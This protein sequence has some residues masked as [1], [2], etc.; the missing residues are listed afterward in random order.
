[1]DLGT[2]SIDMDRQHGYGHATWTWKQNTD[3]DLQFGHDMQHGQVG[4]MLNVQVKVHA[5]PPC[6]C[7][8]SI[9]M[10]HAAYPWPC[11][12]LHVHG[13]A[14]C[15]VHA[16]YHSVWLSWR[17]FGEISLSCHFVSTTFRRNFREINL[18]FAICFW[19]N[20]S[21]RGEPRSVVRS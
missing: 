18:Y 16:A 13:H 4:Y 19:R 3:M 1:M 9:S 6:P 5:T 7:C 17:N 15:P 2:C 14:S 12:M 21:F 20:I 11:C 10:L 8:M